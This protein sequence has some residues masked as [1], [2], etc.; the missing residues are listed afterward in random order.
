MTRGGP[1]PGLG[2]S[3]ELKGRAVRGSPSA[4]CGS[5]IEKKYKEKLQVRENKIEEGMVQR[6]KVA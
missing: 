2:N 5:V 6:G 3:G 1:R 4:V